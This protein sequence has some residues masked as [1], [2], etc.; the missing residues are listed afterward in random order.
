VRGVV[1]VL[2]WFQQDDA[3]LHSS[4]ES[5]A[6]LQQH[7]PDQLISHRCDPQW[8]PHSPNLSPPDLHFWGYLKDRV[9]GNNPQTIPDVKAEIT[10]AVIAIPREECGRVIK[11]FARRIQLCL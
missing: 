11:N 6:W 2:Q 8:S 3:N 5:L 4:N 9:Y 10:A 7:F 1:R